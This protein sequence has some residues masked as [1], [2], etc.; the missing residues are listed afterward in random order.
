MILKI[1]TAGVVELADTSD[2]NS[3]DRKVLRVQIPPLALRLN[4]QTFLKGNTVSFDFSKKKT[5][6]VLSP[7]IEFVENLGLV[8]EGVTIVVIE[9]ASATTNK[10]C[11]MFGVGNWRR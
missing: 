9:L 10:I 6:D 4:P 8:L 7:I 5:E 1:F 3:D 11:R 2:L